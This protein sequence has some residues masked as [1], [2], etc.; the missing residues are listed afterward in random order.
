MNRWET[1]LLRAV[2]EN[3]GSVLEGEV[4]VGVESEVTKMEVIEAGISFR[5]CGASHYVIRLE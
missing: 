1:L 2:R 3:T 5:G 4:G